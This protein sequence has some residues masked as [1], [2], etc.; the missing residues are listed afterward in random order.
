MK[1]GNIFLFDL[2]YY[3][4]KNRKKF[5]LP[6]L[7]AILS[8]YVM[9][10]VCKKNQILDAQAAGNWDAS[11]VKPGFYDWWYYLFAGLEAE[12]S[13]EK[14]L[15]PACWLA[16]NLFLL[17]L[18]SGYISYARKEMGLMA[19]IKCNSMF[20]WWLSKGILSLVILLGYYGILLFCGLLMTALYG[21]WRGELSGVVLMA[22]QLPECQ[23]QQFI[24]PVFA[25]VSLVLLI[26]ILEW[27]IGTVPAFLC[28]TGA[29]IYSAYNATSGWNRLFVMLRRMDGC[30]G[31]VSL[32]QVTMLM[33]C[34]IAAYL[35]FGWILQKN[36]KNLDI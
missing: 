35:V 21:N 11:L 14:F 19:M 8:Y 5:L 18:V 6:P 10:V 30:G 25:G 23:V 22:L 26:Q 1:H 20:R 9:A 27:C 13:G 3:G 17:I 2:I 29:M 16:V 34:C 4:N 31:R 24:A 33:F 28:M 36:R 32:L 12:H 7:F 15:V